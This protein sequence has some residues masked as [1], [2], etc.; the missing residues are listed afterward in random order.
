MIRFARSHPAQAASALFALALLACAPVRAAPPPPDT[1]EDQAPASVSHPVVEPTAPS[2][3]KALNTALGRLAKEPRNTDAL[4]DAGNAALALGD[5]E[6][7]VG[8]FNRADQVAPGNARVKLA[9]AGARLRLDDPVE[10]LR[11]FADAEQA[12]ADPAAFALDRGLAY[13]LVGDSSAAVAEYRKA[14]AHAAD[15]TTRDEALRREAISLAIGGD[16]RSADLALL[17]LLQRQDRAAWRAHVFVLAIA[18]RSDE[19]VAVTR[20]TMPADLAAA[21]GPYLRFMVQL[22][23]AQQ[24]AVASLG[25]FPRAADIGRDDLRVVAYAAAHP[26]VPLVPVAAPVTKLAQAAPARD[27]EGRSRRRK[28]RDAAPAAAAPPLMVATREAD[29]AL[30]PPPPP[31]VM[32]AA[33]PPV[34][35]PVSRTPA[36]PHD[37]FDLGQ[38]TGTRTETPPAVAAVVPRPTV[39]SRLDMP[40]P[41][42]SAVAP[43]AV[44]ASAT[45]A[46]P[47]TPV[48]AYQSTP[49]VQPTVVPTAPAT[50]PAPAPDSH[51]VVQPLPESPAPLGVSAEAAKPP[52]PVPAAPKPAAPDKAGH[53]KPA[54]DKLAQEKPG[55]DKAGLDKAT[56]EKPARGKDAH[57]KAETKTG[58]TAPGESSDDNPRNAKTTSDKTAKGK[59]ARGKA[60]AEAAADADPVP[61]KPVVKA[62]GR[63]A[64]AERH[65]DAAKRSR[66][67]AKGHAAKA[68]T[69][70]CA[71]SAR[72]ARPDG[73][74]GVSR[75]ADSEDDSRPAKG[76]NAKAKG[77][78]RDQ[79]AD[80]EKP[81]KG[82]KH[83]RYASRIWVE[84][85]TGAD[86]DKMPGEWR[87]LVRKTHKLKG[88]K[89]YLTPWRSTFRLLTGPF[90]SDEQAQD[91]IAE[92]RKDGVAGFEWTSPAGQAVDSL[93][94]P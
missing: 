25:H 16:R 39:L 93:P 4:L 34:V 36:A 50:S 45:P 53:D 83:A 29:I 91:F 43:A 66:H 68:D 63:K 20:A 33:A 11:W 73:P 17:P 41:R 69:E 12:G 23:P 86:R 58:K 8:F 77:K 40:P 18:G 56:S 14:R 61:C 24:A 84:V 44:S 57:G 3:G 38:A 46:A 9:M 47:P 74:G 31:P 65:S 55:H 2:A 87:N 60:A 19:A 22:T 82:G 13:A 10:A 72:G 64:R 62:K 32:V 92:L 85:L 37:G 79:A 49:V 35:P 42:R 26:R 1:D 88:R 48:P 7:A 52:S 5:N 94:L 27:G 15:D 54:Q 90:E 67:Q 80:S 59:L 89:P 75:S 30:P 76:K 6:A 78:G 51:P 21:I 28:A 81:V 70:T 71:P